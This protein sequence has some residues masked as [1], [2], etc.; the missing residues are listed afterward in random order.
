MKVENI[1]AAVRIRPFK[2][3][4]IRTG[5]GESYPVRHPEMIALSPDVSVLLVIH[6]PGKTA[7]IDIDSVTEMTD[8]FNAQKTSPDG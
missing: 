7:M 2:P 1:Q 8:D 4:A 6:G 3:F 5:S